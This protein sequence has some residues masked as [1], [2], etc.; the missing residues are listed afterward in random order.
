MDVFR[1]AFEIFDVDHSGAI[2]QEELTSLLH[3]LGFNYSQLEM[4]KIFEEVDTD[5]SGLIEVNEFITFISRQIV[6]F[7]IIFSLILKI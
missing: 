7:I 1:Q 4:A 2:D 5:G 6:T 3:A